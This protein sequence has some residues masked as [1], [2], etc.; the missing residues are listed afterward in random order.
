MRRHLI[1]GAVLVVLSG[2]GVAWQAHAASDVAL[3]KG[4]RPVFVCPLG[5]HPGT[6]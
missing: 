2:G 6:R 1:I 4:D 3:A 5:A